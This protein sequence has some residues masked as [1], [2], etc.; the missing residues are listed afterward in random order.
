MAS[1]AAA[2]AAE[3]VALPVALL[4]ELLQEMLRRSEVSS[5]SCHYPKWSFS[6]YFHC[7]HRR[8]TER[9][10]ALLLSLPPSLCLSTFLPSCPTRSCPNHSS[11]HSFLLFL[12][13][14]NASCRP[15]SFCR[16]YFDCPSNCESCHLFYA[17]YLSSKCLC[18]Y[19]PNFDRPFS[20]S[21]SGR[22]FLSKI[23]LVSSNL[24]RRPFSKIDPCSTQRTSSNLCHFGSKRYLPSR[25]IASLLYP[26]T[27]I[28]HPS[29]PLSS[30][31]SQSSKLH[32]PN[33]FRVISL[34]LARL[35]LR[36]Q[37]LLHP[38]I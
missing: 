9:M 19:Y 31:S 13:S 29:R 12:Y 11:T 18:L 15:T 14:P 25:L 5:H 23:G 24:Q 22:P 32:L 21:C 34:Y 8:Q 20:S 17:N 7:Q 26:R 16:R 36:W 4:L 28:L 30:L 35:P 27:P 10:V 37:R 3:L 38:L 1:L 33:H 6:S 2:S